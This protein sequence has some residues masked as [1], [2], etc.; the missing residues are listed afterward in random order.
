[1]ECPCA[2]QCVKQQEKSGRP[3]LRIY[4]RGVNLGSSLLCQAKAGGSTLL[5]LTSRGG[6]L[7][8]LY[9]SRHEIHNKCQE[10]KVI[11][12]DLRELWKARTLE[13]LTLL[14]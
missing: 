2:R 14:Q 12:A 9:D 3:C 11:K 4:H 13:N 7:P 6:D 5:T 1:M 8:L 10:D